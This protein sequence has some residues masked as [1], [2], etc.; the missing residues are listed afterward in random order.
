MVR[1]NAFKCGIIA[2]RVSRWTNTP[3][4]IIVPLFAARC[5]VDVG[6]DV[7]P[8]VC[9]P[10]IRAVHRATVYDG[11]KKGIKKMSIKIGTSGYSYEDWLGILYPPGTRKADFLEVY[12]QEF[13]IVELNY[14]YYCMPVAKQTQGM[15]SKTSAGFQ[16]SIKAHQTIT[17]NIDKSMINKEIENFL[18]G[19]DPIASAGKLAVV[20]LQFPFSFHYTSENRVAL[21]MVCNGFGTVPLA[22]EFRNSKWQRKSVTDELTSRNIAVVNV[23]EP[24]IDGLMRPE[25]VVTSLSVGYVRFHGRNKENWWSGDNV[26]RYDYLYNETELNEWVERIRAMMVQTA[27]VLV[28]FNNHS[29]GQAV[30]N[31]RRLKQ[32]MG[33]NE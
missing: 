6:E 31:A 14:T 32:L 20:L 26:S 30:Q 28:V 5:D 21:D 23:D 13:D 9:T 1:A 2:I 25:S 4:P 15:V 22:I 17:H 8:H 16:F 11:H 3:Q 18:K 10:G 33:I 19:I 7:R 24:Q 12:S 27:V 29:K